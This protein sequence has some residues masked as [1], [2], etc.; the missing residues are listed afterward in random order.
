MEIINVYSSDF[1][2]TT[3]VV[4][5]DKEAFYVQTVDGEYRFSLGC[6]ISTENGEISEDDYPEID[7][8]IKEAEKYAESKLDFDNLVE[9]PNYYNKDTSPYQTR[10]FK[11]G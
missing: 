11:K 7:V 1:D 3:I 10:F 4:E 6:L 9:N 2:N 8:I 5:T